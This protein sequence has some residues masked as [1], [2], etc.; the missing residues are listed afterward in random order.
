[1]A[2]VPPPVQSMEAKAFFTEMND[3]EAHDIICI[4]LLLHCTN[5]FII[6]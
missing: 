5:S 4:L 1:M 2:K 3:A 6:T